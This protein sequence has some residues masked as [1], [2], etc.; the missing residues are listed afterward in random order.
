LTGL[1]GWALLKSASAAATGGLVV[2]DFGG[3]S[4]VVGL[5][6]QADGNIV[7]AGTAFQ[8]GGV[9]FALARYIGV[10]P[11]QPIDAIISNVQALVASG[12]LNNG[13][14]NALLVKLQHAIQHLDSGNAT[15]A[16]NDLQSFV[17]EVTDYIAQDLLTGAEGQP[18]IDEADSIIAQFT[19]K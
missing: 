16:A 10:L 5:A 1:A 6:I 15:T 2:T 4:Q 14:G 8:P 18:L 12:V 19:K 3:A 9:D 13:E 7:A 17:N 11:S